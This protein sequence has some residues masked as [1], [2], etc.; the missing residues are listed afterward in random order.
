LFRV[1]FDL[2]NETSKRWS[3]RATTVL[4]VPDGDGALVPRP[5]DACLLRR[6]VR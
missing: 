4:A 5:P 1:G 6:P 3:A 2:Y